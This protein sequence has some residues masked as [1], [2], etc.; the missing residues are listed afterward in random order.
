MKYRWAAVFVLA[1]L[2]AVFVGYSKPETPQQIATSLA[3]ENATAVERRTIFTYLVQQNDQWLVDYQPTGE[4]LMSTSALDGLESQIDQMAK[5]FE[6]SIDEVL[7]KTPEAPKT[8]R[9]GL[10]QAQRLTTPF[11]LSSE[12]SKAAV[13]PRAPPA[14]RAVS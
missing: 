4:S 1:T 12:P 14:G 5:D 6:Q 10:Q 11:S 7:E 9:T 2:V 8:E 13:L 3:A